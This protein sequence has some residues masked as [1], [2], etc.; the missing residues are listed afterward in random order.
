[1]SQLENALS[2]L[3]GRIVALGLTNHQSKNIMQGRKIK[4]SSLAPPNK[5]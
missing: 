2:G 1:M 3:G 5:S 4:T